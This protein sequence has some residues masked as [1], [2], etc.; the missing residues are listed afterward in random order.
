MLIKPNLPSEKM[1]QGSLGFRALLDKNFF[2][3]ILNFY[4]KFT[5]TRPR[6]KQFFPGLDRPDPNF[7]SQPQRK[8]LLFKT[9]SLLKIEFFVTHSKIS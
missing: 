6:S 9:K 4:S 3:L 2:T 1:D 7:L 8:D 5:S